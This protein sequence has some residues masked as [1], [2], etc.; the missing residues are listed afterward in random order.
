[1]KKKSNLSR[2]LSY[3]GGHK[4]LT[5]LGCT[6]SGIAA[7]LG[8]MPFVCVWL[9]A[10]DA[11][12]VYPSTAAALGLVRW[13]WMAVWFAVGNIVVYFA[14]LMCTHIAAFRTARN[15]R[16]AGV[17]H[18]LELPL[19]FFAADQSGRLRKIIDDNAA[20]TEDLLAH[21]LPDL[22]AA[23]VTPLASIVLLLAF[24]W[25]M[26]LLCLLTM[27]MALCCMAAMM[28]GK[29]AGFFH[30][31]QREI[32]K[33]SGEAVEYVR[34]I[35]VVK[36][37]QQT[38]YSFK[39][40]YNAIMSYS[41][42]A[43]EYAMSCRKGQTGFLTCINGAFFLLIPAALLLA[44]HGNGW[45]VLAD[46]IFYVLFAPACGGMI[47]RI[48]YASESVMEANEAMMKL[49]EIMEQPPLP[50][51]KAPKT[52]QENRVAFEHVTFRYPGTERPALNDVSFCVEEGAVAALVGPSG[53][54]KSTACKLAARFWDIQGGK[55]TLGGV[56]ISTVEPETLLKH[57]S[58]VFQDVVLFRDTVMENIRLGRRGAGDEEVYAA[59]RAARCDEFIRR[60]P[61]G[62][63]TMVGENGSTLSGG[64]RQRI[65]IARALLKDAPVILLD[66]ATASLDVENE[67][68]VQE[69][70]SRL[71]KDKT[72]LIIAHRMRTV[73]GADKIVVL[74]D[75]HVAEQGAPQALLEQ[76]GIYA[77]MVALQTE[78]H[79]WVLAK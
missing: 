15:I 66:E 68:A 76:N 49:D 18:M 28:G 64:E 44:S 69:A 70:L 38:V 52:P 8:L 54:G 22:T 4:K 75:G 72:V 35:P 27:V 74:A 25:R 73:A 40:F 24:D 6:L 37:F 2:L 53:G 58:F 36:V 5:V 43:S 78:S 60:L 31:Y 29:N 41:N 42:L 3:A 39:A 13:G 63:Q 57:Y 47:N 33:M 79:D 16:Q 59:A 46:F 67:T 30:R 55:I 12:A 71:V 51:P 23:V 48:M 62:Y 1:M 56:D 32:E 26:G 11:L 10:R 17:A 9:V 21:K 45:A 34:G 20:L 50:A 65:S 14:A 61:Q 77:S 7:L 19:G